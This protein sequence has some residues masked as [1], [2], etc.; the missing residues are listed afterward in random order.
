M[1]MPVP[2]TTPS[3]LTG[4]ELS[5]EVPQTWLLIGPLA[6]ECAHWGDALPLLLAHLQLVQPRA[7]L[8]QMDLPGTGRLCGESS[9]SAVATLVGQLRQ[10]V[11]KTG[12]QGPFGLI[13]SS[14]ACAL[15]VE[16]AR[17]YP[18]ELG[19]L[20]LLSPALRPFTPVL[21][22][23]RPSLWPHALAKVMGSALPSGDA[24]RGRAL[25]REH[26]VRLRTGLAQLL[27]VW[28]YSASRRRPHGQVLLLAGKGDEWL[29][30]RVSSA[31]SRAWGAALR[32]HPEA[33]HD[34]LHD[35]AAW[36][37]RSV[38]E[39]LLPVGSGGFNSNFGALS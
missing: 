10:R 36:V 19:S 9:P 12:L 37:G 34:L 23:V 16:W 31:I 17:R 1:L 29:D 32:L 21:R 4:P 26:P 14:W 2:T 38:A 7:Q 39:W 13:A 22:S 33:G 30:W 8:F 24:Q 6:R 11:V 20:V 5:P 15:A 28:R 3:A 25:L 18:D 35:D 27:A